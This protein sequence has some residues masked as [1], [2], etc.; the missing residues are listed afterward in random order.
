MYIGIDLG[1]TNI[2]V[3]LVDKDGNII[4]KAST[5]TLSERPWQEIVAD[6]A[7][8]TQKVTE[9]AGYSIA[10]IEAVG[11]GSPGSVDNANG[12][13]AYACNIGFDNSP[14]ADEFRKYINVPVNLE[15]DAN[16]AA[17]GE[18][19]KNGEESPSFVFV[20]LGTGVGGGIVLDGKIY[21]GFNGV[22]AEIGHTVI[23]V[24]G[25][26][27]NCGRSGCWEAYAS[28][29]ALINQTK[30]KMEENPDSL[31]HSVTEKYHEVNG[32]V[33]FE[34]MEMGDEAAKTV[35]ENYI[36]YIGEGLVNII[37]TF[38][39][40]KV[41]IGGGISKEGDTLLTPIKEFIE[42]NDYNKH[43]KKTKIE[44]AKLYNDAGII[45]AAM[46]AMK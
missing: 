41:V 23:I 34:A 2:A 11:I 20:T 4:N 45:G 25:I 6:M 21:R 18:Y 33:A 3:G 13:I 42:K 30:K 26:K 39:P 31:M 24:D 27:C 29:T 44:I 1:G 14:V 35:C 8:L 15:N 36:R 40:E 38:Q 19:V 37:N 9:E 12:I 32:R 5:P 28:V 16:A 22:G 46:S 17:F 7:F 10:D 43:M